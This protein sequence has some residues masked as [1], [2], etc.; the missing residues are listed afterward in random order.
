MTTISDKDGFFFDELSDYRKKLLTKTADL[1]PKETDDFLK[2]RAR[3]LNKIQ[4]KIARQDVGTSKGK[5]KKWVREKSYH[6]RFKAGKIYK[7]GGAKAIRAYNSARHGHLIE[8]G[9][10]TKSGKFVQGRHVIKSSINEYRPKYHS[11]VEEFLFNFFSDI[12]K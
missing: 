6:Y 9:H 8:N 7:Y 11:A 1:F 2:T 4:K 10:M 5:N 3:E 12:G